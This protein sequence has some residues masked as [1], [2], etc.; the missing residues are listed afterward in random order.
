MRACSRCSLHCCGQD[1]RQVRLL[2]GLE[3]L[4][5]NLPLQVDRQHWDSEYGLRHLDLSTAQA[6]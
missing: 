5:E 2:V 6:V 3:A 1:G 4:L